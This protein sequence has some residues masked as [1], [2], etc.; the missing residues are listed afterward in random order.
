VSDQKAVVF[1][2]DSTFFHAGMAGLANLKYN[3][4]KILVVVMDNS[5]TAMTGHQPHPGTGLGPSGEPREPIR[6]E[7]VVRSFGIK[8][9]MIA[10]A[11]S[12][13]ELQAAVRELD[14]KPGVSVLIS[15]GMCRL[16]M[17]RMIRRQGGSFPVF[18]IM[19]RERRDLSMLDNFACP[20]ILKEGGRYR[21]SPDMCWG[22]SVCSQICP[23][24]A[25]K[26]VAARKVKG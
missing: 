12:Q 3:D 14:S 20:A 1:I 23:P 8:N 10:S 7:D 16:L 4:P 21:I 13:K 9:V 25:I 6:I 19:E 18:Q 15:R 24:G 17:K 22:C 5:I 11:Y 2:G 26:P